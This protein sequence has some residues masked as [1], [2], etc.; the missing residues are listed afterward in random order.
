MAEDLLE[1]LLQKNERQ[2]KGGIKVVWGGTKMERKRDK[3]IKWAGQLQTGCQSVHLSGHALQ[4]PHH[5]SLCCLLIKLFSWVG[6]VP[7]LC[8]WRC[9]SHC[10]GDYR[11]LCVL[12]ACGWRLECVHV[13]W[14]C[15]SVC[16]HQ[17]ASSQ[18]SQPGGWEAWEPGIKVAI[19]LG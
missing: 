14:V 2:G 16:D 5:H 11:G 17:Q 9:A 3:K 1:D 12:G 10:R 8:T 18:T 7:V 15:V 6:G 4:V 13:V 19:I